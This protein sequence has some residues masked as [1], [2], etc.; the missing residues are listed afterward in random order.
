MKNDKLKRGLDYIPLL[1]LVILFAALAVKI[2]T[3]ENAFQWKHILGIILI[4]INLFLFYRN[5]KAG[6]LALCVVLLTGLL[7]L[8]SY[9][10]STGTYTFT[11]GKDAGSQVPVFYGQP[12]FLLWL[13]LHFVISFR[14]YVGILS[15]KY[16]IQFKEEVFNKNR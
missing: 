3:T 5:H 10:V 15:K 2:S 11:I 8:I 16:W 4:S 1:A 7:G 12:I 9:N 6:V 14:Y 13:L